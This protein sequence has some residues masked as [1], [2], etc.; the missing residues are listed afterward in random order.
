MQRRR[1]SNGRSPP[2]AAW[3]E[4]SASAERAPSRCGAA[5]L[6]ESLRRPGGAPGCASG[7]SARLGPLS[8]GSIT[9][10]GPDSTGW[11][12]RRGGDLDRR[13]R[14][15]GESSTPLR[16]QSALA[17]SAARGLQR[18]RPRGACAAAGAPPGGRAPSLLG[19][20]LCDTG[21]SIRPRKPGSGCPSTTM[22]WAWKRPRGF[23]H[24]LSVSE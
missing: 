8:L 18:R 7:P 3:R 22:Y 13:P 4:A 21:P 17:I 20:Q 11:Q 5:A 24:M 14:R 16:A 19:L 6:G 1:H 10:P 2:A 12:A 15:A 23:G 9:G